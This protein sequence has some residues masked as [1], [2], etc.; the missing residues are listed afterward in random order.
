MGAN[1]NPTV[2][3]HLSDG[4]TTVVSKERQHYVKVAV[5]ADDIAKDGVVDSAK[6]ARILQLIQ[7]NAADATR[8]VRSSPMHNQC[9]L[10]GV[11]LTQNVQ[12][13][14]RH[15]LGEPWQAAFTIKGY[16]GSIPCSLNA[17]KDNGGLDSATTACVLPTTTG[18]FDIMICG[19]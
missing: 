13:Q 4:T 5:S 12:A 7:D 11:S 1:S 16:E 14:L 18:K 19:T 8:P 6:L 3:T 15:T 10:R 17:V 9:V 2:I